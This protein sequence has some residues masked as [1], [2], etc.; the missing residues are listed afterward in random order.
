MDFYDFMSPVAKL[1]SEASQ[2]T[3]EEYFGLSSLR[4]WGLGSRVECVLAIINQVLSATA[5]VAVARVG[6]AETCPRSLDPSSARG[7]N[8]DSNPSATKCCEI[9]QNIW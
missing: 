4:V 1:T 3:H 5:R 6:P 7:T 8:V 2:Q 9:L